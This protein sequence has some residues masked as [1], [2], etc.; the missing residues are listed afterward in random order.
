VRQHS[1]NAMGTDRR[2][3]RTRRSIH[4]ALLGLM[5]ETDYDSITVQ[6]ILERANVGRSTFY[7]HYANRDEILVASVGD[8]H[9]M[10]GA[11]HTA[12]RGADRYENV[13]AFSLAMFEHAAEYKKVYRALAAAS[14][15]P[16]VRQGI[17]NVLA[18]LMR[19]DLKALR[20]KSRVPEDLLVQHLAAGFMSV[21]T[22]WLEQRGSMPAA[23]ADALYRVLALPVLRQLA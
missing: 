11:A 13:I 2:I 22:W 16:R 17:Q 14:I 3:Q 10:L 21:L 9:A 18:E 8:L 7:A 4:E 20:V 19:R 23:E 5:L 12:R 15:W 6:Q 1:V